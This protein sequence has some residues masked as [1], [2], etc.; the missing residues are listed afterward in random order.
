LA[1]LAASET[2]HCSP[3]QQAKLDAWQQRQTESAKARRGGPWKAPPAQLCSNS[4]RGTVKLCLG[5]CRGDSVEND[6]YGLRDGQ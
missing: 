5:S 2:A 3:L 4:W 1:A 6:F